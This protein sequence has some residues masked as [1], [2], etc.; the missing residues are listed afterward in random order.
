MQEDR[1]TADYRA[2]LA[3][4]EA[5]IPGSSR[6]Q[7]ADERTLARAREVVDEIHPSLAQG[8][9][10][11]V[12]ALDAAAVAY[13][14][15]PF[16]ALSAHRQEE[17]V[18]RWQVDPVL[19][20]PL[21]VLALV[22]KFAHFDR[23]DVYRSMGGKLNVVTALEQ[24]RWL[25]QVHRAD[26]WNEG[27]LEC[28]VVVVGTGAGGGVVGR[29][30]ADRGFAVVY[31]EEGEHHRR[32]SFDGRAI[33]AHQRFYRGAISV[34][35]A[36]MP[37]FMGRLVGGSTAIN[38][39][40]SFRTPG[41]VLDEWCEALGS[42]ALSPAAM[43]PYF[44][45]VEQT[46]E[47]A[48]S[49]RDV[50]GPIGDFVA[51]GCD[52]LGWSHFPVP[53]NAPG[54]DG[55]GFCDFG[56][57]T[58]ARKG[59]NLSYVP[60]ALGKGALL[61]TGARVDRVSL[62]GGRATGVEAVT[63]RGKRVRVRARAVIL[64]GGSIPTPLLLLK[65]GLGNASGQVGRNL[66]LH[67]STGYAA[68]AEEPINGAHHIPQGYGC[69]EF[70]RDGMLILGAQ[71]DY[72]VTGVVFPFVGHRLM[73]AIDRSDHM[74]G[75][76]LL[77]RDQSA[78]GRV[79]RDVGGLPAVTYNLGPEDVRRMHDM[80]VRTSEMALEAGAKTLYPF[81]VGH[82]PLE[83]RRDL[84]AFR[85]ESLGPGD[86]VWTSYHPL[87][88]CRMGRDPK[89]SVV[90]TDHA[91]HGVPGLFVVDGSVVRGPI[92]VNP[93]LTIMAVATRAGGRIAERLT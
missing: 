18:A 78:N 24:P 36:P 55:K 62:D 12:R 31:V 79:W 37:I 19:R 61:L 35:N 81:V 46:L 69:D 68:V 64:A 67:P 44:E 63:P 17:L 11:A 29:E 14:G 90:D 20:T 23:D 85:R 53:R 56:C 32:D 9:R 54:C 41:W 86:F 10:L 51:R 59:T 92:G 52:A 71:A 30:L 38:G 74:A 1:T 6:V 49:P 39:G 40:T 88:T 7:A 22:L 48:P 66:S 73:E 3:L 34:G 76:G 89:T 43:A 4:A 80:M 57:R 26:D 33:S 13:A 58:D 87:G 27:D 60:A 45:K 82:P 65:Q 83:G 21:G 72:N 28:D 70:L 91:V 16:H 42:D 5:I 77:V 15:R 47:V 93:Q 8:W 2:G 75:F 25:A 50:I 84:E